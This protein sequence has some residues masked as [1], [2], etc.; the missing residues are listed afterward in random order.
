[1]A[2]E[3]WIS[4]DEELWNWDSG[5]DFIWLPTDIAGGAGR[6]VAK[7]VTYSYVGNEVTWI[8]DSNIQAWRYVAPK[9]TFIYKANKE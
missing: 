9:E 7:S 4:S 1:M 5:D 3:E 6:F 8:Y 2:T